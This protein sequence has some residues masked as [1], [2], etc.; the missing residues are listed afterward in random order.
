MDGLLTVTVN[1]M[2]SPMMPLFGF[3]TLLTTKPLLITLTIALSWNAGGL[4]HN[5][6]AESHSIVAILLIQLPVAI[7]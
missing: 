5:G 3:T 6:H 7:H 2:M 1:V 4:L